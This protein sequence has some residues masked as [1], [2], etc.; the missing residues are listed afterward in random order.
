MLNPPVQP[1]SSRP[2][3]AAIPNAYTVYSAATP[4][5]RT[6]QTFQ[7]YCLF[8]LRNRPAGFFGTKY[9]LTFIWQWC[10]NCFSVEWKLAFTV[11]VNRKD[12]K[13]NSCFWCDAAIPA[14][15]QTRVSK[16]MLFGPPDLRKEIQV[17]RL[18]LQGQGFIYAQ[19]KSRFAWRR[20]NQNS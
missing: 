18:H 11:M 3:S 2:T 16:P 19:V 6:L 15:D 17:A 9:K 12:E 20:F 13:G 10:F 1:P 8:V 4:N 5:P 7:K 14:W